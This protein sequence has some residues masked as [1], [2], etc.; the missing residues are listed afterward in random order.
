MS[1]DESNLRRICILHVIENLF[2][3]GGTP[4]KLLNLVRYSDRN[5]FRHVFLV[6]ADNK[7]SLKQEFIEAGAIVVEVDRRRNWDLRLLCDIF[8]VAHRYKAN[9]ISTHFARADIY[10]AIAGMLTRTPVIKN[11]HGMFWNE[12]H[13][14]QRIDAALSR[15]RAVTICNSNATS[16]AV[17][18]QTSAKNTI[19]IHNGVPNRAINIE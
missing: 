2:S 19:V 15:F 16:N 18:R 14:L 12:S 11:V 3:H 7:A 8:G 10:G 6:F 4:I 13:W 17:I 5:R 9:I 1:K